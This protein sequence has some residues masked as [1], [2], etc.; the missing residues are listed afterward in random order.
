VISFRP[1]LSNHK[2]YYSD[3]RTGKENE[4]GKKKFKENMLHGGLKL[5]FLMSGVKDVSD[6]L[7]EI[8]HSDSF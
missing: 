6:I 4:M 2:R 5:A 1:P 7:Y 8:I 3:D